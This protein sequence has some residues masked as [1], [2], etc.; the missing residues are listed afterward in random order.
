M[1]KFQIGETVVGN[2][3]A[4]EE[5]NI[6]QCGSLVVVMTLP[7]TEG[8]FQGKCIQDRNGRP[9]E[10]R[11]KYFCLDIKHFDSDSLQENE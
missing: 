3:L 9:Y 7:D 2:K 5:Y 11:G 6:T 1:S 10:H 8:Y 4:D